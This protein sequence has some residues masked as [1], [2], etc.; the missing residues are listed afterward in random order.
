MSTQ[1][2]ADAGPIR[3]DQLTVRTAVGDRRHYVVEQIQPRHFAQ[4]ARIADAP[5]SAVDQR[6]AEI[7]AIAPC[8]IDA[9]YTCVARW[10]SLSVLDEIAE[11]TRRGLHT[12]AP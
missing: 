10:I 12:I 8:A 2:N 3:R 1:P 6:L 11:R 9:P 7:A 5:N 4:T